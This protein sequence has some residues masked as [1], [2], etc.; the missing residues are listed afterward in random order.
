[1][2]VLILGAFIGAGYYGWTKKSRWMVIM[3]G[4]IPAA[5]LTYYLAGIGTA[6]A[7]GQGHFYSVPF[8]GFSVGSNDVVL[9]G[10]VVFWLLIWIGVLSL[11]TRKFAPSAS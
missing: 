6:L 10:S 4:S 3:F 2:I 8:G 11:L 9:V 7:I 5:L 1:M